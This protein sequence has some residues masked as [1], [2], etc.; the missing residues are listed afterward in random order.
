VTTYQDAMNA[1]RSAGGSSTNTSDEQHDQKRHC[2]LV[3][4]RTPRDSRDNPIHAIL[5]VYN[6]QTE[7]LAQKTFRP[8]LGRSLHLKLSGIHDYSP[9]PGRQ[10]HDGLSSSDLVKPPAFPNPETWNT[11]NRTSPSATIDPG[12]RDP[13]KLGDLFDSE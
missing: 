13:K 10:C 9:L 12:N 8:G 4:L 11:V 2:S 3:S 1:P 6:E 7:R 5:A